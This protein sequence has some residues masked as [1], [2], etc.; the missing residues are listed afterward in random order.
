MPFCRLR[1]WSL[2]VLLGLGVLFVMATVWSLRS[3]PAVDQLTD[4]PQDPVALTASS[5]LGGGLGLAVDPER[6]SSGATS[7]NVHGGVIMSELG[8]ATIR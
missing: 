5:W 3:S 2:A 8:N 1:R 6:W 4:T 7:A